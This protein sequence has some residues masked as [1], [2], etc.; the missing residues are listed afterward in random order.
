MTKDFISQYQKGNEELN[1]KGF[2]GEKNV[3]ITKIELLEKL[4][5]AQQNQIEAST[6]QL[7]NAYE[8][9]QNIAVKAVISAQPPK[10][11]TSN[12]K[13]TSPEKENAQ[14]LKFTMARPFPDTRDWGG[15]LL[16]Y[17]VQG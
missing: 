14:R 17:A 8:K 3:L 9:V 10:T 7:Q 6:N 11:I 15:N 5:S 4:V 2:E 13:A 16:W 12:Q 1:S